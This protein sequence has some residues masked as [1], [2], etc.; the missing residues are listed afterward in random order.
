[1]LNCKLIAASIYGTDVSDLIEA[2]QIIDVNSL[3]FQRKL[4]LHSPFNIFSN[5]E[6][7]L[8]SFITASSAPPFSKIRYKNANKKAG[9]EF[10]GGLL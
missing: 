9:I 10:S 6:T 7:S 4:T 2:K 8:S 5:L 3:L 1:M